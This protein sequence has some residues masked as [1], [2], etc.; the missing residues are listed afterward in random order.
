[1]RKNVLITV[2]TVFCFGLL[3]VWLFRPAKSKHDIERPADASGTNGDVQRMSNTTAIHEPRAKIEFPHEANET[4]AS[5]ISQTNA[6]ALQALT[7]AQEEWNRKLNKPIEFYGKVVDENDQPVEGAAA[8]FLYNR[9]SSPA[10]SFHTNSVSDTNGL[11]SISGLTGSTLSVDVEKNSYYP[12]KS[13]NE[14]HFD[15]LTHAASQP[16]APDA[17]NPIVFH[18]RKR[19]IGAELIT[20]QNGM[21]P[22]LT[23]S[24]LKDG[25]IKRVDFFNHQVGNE[26]QLELS[27][28]KPAP[29]QPQSEWSFRLSIPDGGLLEEND[30]FPFEAPESGYT[31]KIDFHFRAGDTN[32]T[33]TLQKHFYVKFG[34][35]PKYGW[36]SIDSAIDRGTYL[37]YAINPDGSRN[38]EPA[39]PQPEQ[40][41]GF[42]PGSRI[43][44]PKF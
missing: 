36:V 14:N 7:N 38:L 44:T 43:I 31:P 18:L 8:S 29:G 25:S 11:F 4:R 24:G 22:N 28:I 2:I 40:P 35:P 10:G 16:F 32:W 3:L 37:R 19:K 41:Q 5:N 39:E 27:A 13:A 21:R 23:I 12:V 26:G 15:Y 33:T 42:P 17:N 9:F 30:E 34:Q 20:S 1:M 6:N